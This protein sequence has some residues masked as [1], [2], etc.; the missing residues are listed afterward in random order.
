MENKK[1][2]KKTSVPKKDIKDIEHEVRN[3]VKK[4]I[5]R[6]NNKAKEKYV[7][8]KS[9]KISAFTLVEMMAV[10]ALIAFLSVVAVSTYRGVNESAKQKTLD[11]KVMEI[12]AAAEKW[13]RDNNITSRVTLSINTLVV[14]GYLPADEA[15]TNG[16]STIKN[17]VTGDNMICSTVDILFEEGV[18]KVIYND[19][20]KDCRLASQSIE[21]ANISVRVVDSD[22][23]TRTGRGSISNWTNKDVELI[24]SSNKYDSKVVS[25]SYD[26]EG[27]TITRRKSDLEEYTGSSFVK[28]EDVSRYYNVY[29]I[30]ASLLLNSKIVIT[31]ELTDGSTKS[32]VYT[33]RIDKEE[34]TAVADT[35]SEWLTN[36]EPISIKVDDGKGSGPKYFYLT[37]TPEWSN[38]ALRYEANY[39]G[40]TASIP[41]GKYYVWTEDNAGN[42]SANYKI[43]VDVNNVDKVT[44]GCE[45]LFHGTEGNNGWFI[46]NVTPGAQNTPAAS[47]SGVNV[48][49]NTSGTAE[50]SAFAQHKTQSEAT[51]PIVTT[52]TTKTGTRY[53]CYA[54]SLSGKTATA[55]RVLKIDKTPPTVT[56]SQH[57]DNSYTRSK[58]VT[59]DIQDSL[60]GLNAITPFRYG[61][62]LGLNG[63]ISWVNSVITAVPATN[64][65]ATG[66]ISGL[67][68]TGDYYLWIDI[69]GVT[70]YA[71]NGGA[72]SPGS[73]QAGSLVYGPFKFDN[74]PPSCSSGSITNQCTTSGVTAVINCSD[75]HSGVAICAGVSGVTSTT[76]TG[77]KAST[78]YTVVDGAGN[79]NKCGV[80]VNSTK[81]YQKYTC[82]TGKRCQAAGCETAKRCP[83]AACETWNYC[84]HSDCGKTNQYYTC[85]ACCPDVE[86]PGDIVYADSCGDGY[87]TCDRGDFCTRKVNAS[88][89]TSGCGCETRQR[90][91]DKCGCETW[92]RSISLCEC[93]TWNNPGAWTNTPI[94]ECGDNKHECKVGERTVYSTDGTCDGG[95]HTPGTSTGT[96]GMCG[97]CSANGD[98]SHGGSCTGMCSNSRGSYR[99][100][101]GVNLE[102][103]N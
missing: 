28:R 95:T 2:K 92:Y 1:V 7:K 29:Y 66:I 36:E 34:A 27:N 3:V 93:E 19:K 75:G 5:K 94:T 65:V 103:C 101:V 98:C 26:F 38:D 70:D 99:C 59:I 22:N 90:D 71:G 20:V 47:V 10:F 72:T 40:K 87:L 102:M 51:L 43:E 96:V 14:E 11:A 100:C 79:T 13:A 41:I 97:A 39:K 24:V 30:E 63:D 81:Q 18:I 56:I 15:D 64:D 84:Q 60:S 17:P 76:K 50:Y 35:N 80:Y 78:S 23:V 42:R 68:Y 12:K 16:M 31:Y 52:E 85:Y 21:D 8:N 91:Y 58:I 61:W 46:S 83:E 88:C 9:I 49:I 53:F 45:V 4:A 48:G 25:I 57:S 77:L 6:R 44:P 54:K 32:K 69:S 73:L 74:T 62:S 37:T 67:G 55:N 89:R 86:T 82:N 33:I